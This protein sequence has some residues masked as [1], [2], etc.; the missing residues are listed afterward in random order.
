MRLDQVGGVY[1]FHLPSWMF[2]FP[3]WDMLVLRVPYSYVSC[4]LDFEFHCF[5]CRA[6]APLG[7]SPQERFVG[8]CP[9]VLQQLVADLTLQGF[10][11]HD[12]KGT[13]SFGMVLNE[14]TWRWWEKF[15]LWKSLEFE[16]GF[17]LGMLLQVAYINEPN[18][19]EGNQLPE[20]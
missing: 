18:Q 20:V 5:L 14:S 10:L 4:F 8:T 13:R 19:P 6:W 2:L 7:W 17:E 11:T 16:L 3:S 15:C 9:E 1:E 12:L